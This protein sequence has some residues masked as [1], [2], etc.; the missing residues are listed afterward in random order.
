M[1]KI[2]WVEGCRSKVAGSSVVYGTPFGHLIH[3]YTVTCQIVTLIKDIINFRI[4]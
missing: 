2:V 3:C 4:L 1:C